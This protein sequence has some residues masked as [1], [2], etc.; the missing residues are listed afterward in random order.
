MSGH[1]Y[2]QAS[3]VESPNVKQWTL[4]EC[5]DYALDQN[6][7]LRQNKIS[8]LESEIDVKSARASLFPSLSFNSGHNIT[9]RPYQQN[10]STVNGTEIIT[11]NNKTT[12]SGNYGLSANWTVW[13]G[14]KKV[15]NLKQQK[16]NNQ[17]A[18]LNVEQT[19][20][21]LQEQIT[22]L[23]IQILYA[24]ESVRI[25]ENTVEVSQLT[26]NRG[27]DLY[28]EGSISKVDL[29]QLEAQLSNDKYQLVTSENALRNYKLQLK[30]LL[31]LDGTEEMQLIL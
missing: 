6:I 10:S 28:I 20:N 19:E 17:I 15:N 27:N 1:L 25:N 21:S 13:D 4:Q 23:F 5:I 9:N 2:G 29:A 12:Y 16:L 11:S 18:E 22:Q 30:Q 8:T 26:Y 24:N 14:N 31:E 7:Q 3:E